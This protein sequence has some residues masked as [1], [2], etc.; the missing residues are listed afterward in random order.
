MT[1]NAVD[2]RSFV[3]FHSVISPSHDKLV[4]AGISV[5]INK[6][7]HLTRKIIP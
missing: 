2:S 3:V 7:L 5:R 1:D 4:S 6:S